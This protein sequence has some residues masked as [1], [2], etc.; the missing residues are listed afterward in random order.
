MDPSFLE[1]LPENIRQEVIAEQMRLQRIRQ[2]A[3]EQA[4][5]AQSTGSLQVSPEFLAALPPNIQE[6]VITPA[7]YILICNYIERKELWRGW[8]NTCKMSVVMIQ[9]CVI[10]ELQYPLRSTELTEYKLLYYS[11]S[12]S[13]YMK[14][15][16]LITTY[17]LCLDFL[18]LSILQRPERH[19]RS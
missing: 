12:T 9:I 3:R 1:A 5:T 14:L 18:L 6:E 11:Y 16:H 19:S 2:S 8:G 15:F 17:V 13:E 10:P 4:Q 7:F